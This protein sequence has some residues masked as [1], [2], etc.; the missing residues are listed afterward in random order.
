MTSDVSQ[1][2][3]ALAR[4]VGIPLTEPIG[5]R[6]RLTPAGRGTLRVGPSHPSDGDLTARVRLRRRPSIV[7][8]QFK[9]GTNV[10]NAGPVGA[11]T[12]F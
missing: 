4:E 7:R 6:V 12:Y 11:P 9:V 5:R 3:A 8:W 1:G 10:G 2:L